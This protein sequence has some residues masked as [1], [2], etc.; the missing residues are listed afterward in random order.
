MDSL[1]KVTTLLVSSALFFYE[2]GIFMISGVEFLETQTY[3][4]SLVSV[5][6]EI[7]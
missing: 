3:L 6:N 1:H 2:A 4:I 7:G 5:K